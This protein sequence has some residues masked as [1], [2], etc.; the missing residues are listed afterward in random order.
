M[1]TYYHDV[2]EY[3]KTAIEAKQNPYADTIPSH[4]L[5]E[6]KYFK[7]S[8]NP[9]DYFNISTL[10]LIHKIKNYSKFT[11]HVTLKQLLNCGYSSCW[12]N[13]EQQSILNNMTTLS[14]HQENLTLYQLLINLKYDPFDGYMG[15]IKYK[16][17]QQIIL[18]NQ[19]AFIPWF[20]NW[21]VTY[22]APIEDLT[23]FKIVFNELIATLQFLMHDACE[24]LH[25]NKNPLVPFDKYG[26]SYLTNTY[27]C[28]EHYL[29]DYLDFSTSPYDYV[30][31]EFILLKNLHKIQKLCCEDEIPN[32]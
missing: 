12:S 21:G 26:I 1:I 27:D 16:H 5:D 22:L 11:P 20:N 3:D 17:L 24:Y 9:I 13:E 10:R 19:E 28:P 15:D 2:T 6:L 30:L 31:Y 25:W 8:Y 14:S 7:K 4:P 32:E 29:H 23:K 18:D